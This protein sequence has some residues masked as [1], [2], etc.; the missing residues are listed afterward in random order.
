LEQRASTLLAL[1]GDELFAHGGCHVFALA[2]KER[3]SYPLLWVREE[4]GPHDH[5]ACAP[6][7]GRLLDVFGWFSHD[8]YRREEMLDRRQISFLLIQEEEVKRRFIFAPG[9]GYYAHPDFFCPATERA[10]TWIA[11]YR[12]YFDGTRKVTIPS[13]HRVKKTSGEDIFQEPA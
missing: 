1:P 7:H 13:L 10:R 8:E 6:E 3:F 2:L 12:E 11:K 9:Q 5:V 4:G